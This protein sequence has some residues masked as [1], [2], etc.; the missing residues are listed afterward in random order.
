MPSTTSGIVY[1][2]ASDDVDVPGDMQAMA[3]SIEPYIAIPLVRLILPANQ[4]IPTGTD[5]PA[6]FG[7]NSEI[8]DTHNFH[9]TT[10]N[11]SRVTPTMPGWYLCQ[12]SPVWNANTTGQRVHFMAKNGVGYAPSVRWHFALVNQT[13]ALPG[14]QAILSANGTTDYFEFFVNQASGGALSLLGDGNQTSVFNTIFE[15]IYLRPL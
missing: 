1:P 6:S 5:T 11:P 2:S 10:V 3:N 15:V 13:T 7:A 12:G 9:S 4:S 14:S 8:V